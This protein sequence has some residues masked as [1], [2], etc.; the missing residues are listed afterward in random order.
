MLS[1]PRIS[2]DNASVIALKF[3]EFIASDTTALDRLMSLTGLSPGDLQTG[4][5]AA[6]F[7][8]ALLDYA[9]QNEP[10]LL[11]FA[12]AADIP[13]AEIVA[14]RQALPGAPS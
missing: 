6:E 7:Q 11:A 13:P 5:V 4:A 12:A 14:A 1:K 2:A 8:G 10:L 3:M 9:L